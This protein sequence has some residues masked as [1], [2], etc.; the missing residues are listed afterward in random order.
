[1]WR[2]WLINWTGKR[3][4]IS[5]LIESI[6]Y[7]E[8]IYILVDDSGELERNRAKVLEI[9]VF[10]D[11]MIEALQNIPVEIREELMNVDEGLQM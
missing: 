11:Y 1:M 3:I 5:L 8:I 9:N 6:Y 7:Y 4:K 10:L 2:K